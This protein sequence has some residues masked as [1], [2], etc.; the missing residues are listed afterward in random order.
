MFRDILVYVDDT[1]Q[2]AARLDLAAK[3]TDAASGHVAGLAVAVIGLVED[4][5]PVDLLDEQ[6][7][8]AQNRHARLERAFQEAMRRAGV[9]AEWQATDTLTAGLGLLDVVAAHARHRDLLVVSQPAPDDVGQ[10]LPTDFAGQLALHAGRPV[11]ALP[12]AWEGGDV[13][14][15][16]LIAWDGGRACA[17]AVHDALP[18][19][20]AAESARVVMFSRGGG[21]A[22]GLPGADIATHLA[23]HDVRVESDYSV[24]PDVRVG[25]AILSEASDYSAD[26]IVMGAYERARLREL[27][28]GGVT[29][30]VVGHL[31]VPVL[32][33]H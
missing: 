27:L 22:G 21:A 8:D 23:R 25:E 10:E 15:R 3:L 26:L 6:Q 2:C 13:G 18:M 14:R 29:R 5:A 19:L 33:S 30:D 16:A 20:K 7:R 9:H 17:R 1:D 4:L 31:T 28:L 11:L 12:S 32:L 24:L